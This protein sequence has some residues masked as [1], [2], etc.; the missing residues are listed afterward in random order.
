MKWFPSTNEINIKIMDVVSA[1]PFK[2]SA[3][4]VVNKINYNKISMFNIY[5]NFDTLIT[6]VFQYIF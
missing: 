2:E 1:D 6:S 4:D 5:I 3:N